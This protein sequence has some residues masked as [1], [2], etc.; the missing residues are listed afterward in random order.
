MS[1]VP[2]QFAAAA[3]AH[4]E[5]QL[6]L[7]NTL[8]RKAFEGVEKAIGLNV[9]AV[10]SS[11]EQATDTAK[12]LSTSGNPQ[13]FLAA[14]AQGQ[15]NPEKAREYTRQMTEIATNMHAEFTRAA[16]AQVAE[17]RQKLATLVEEASKNAPPGSEAAIATMKSILL[18]ADTAYEQLARNAKQAA[19]M[20]QTSVKTA[21]EQAARSME[22]ASRTGKK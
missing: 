8:T 5:A 7:I 19:E 22:K 4:F 15:P 11:L 17:T 1:N 3:K 21:S 12:K 13:D 16:E 14:A 2:E 18:S 20:L 9:D 10:K 6:A